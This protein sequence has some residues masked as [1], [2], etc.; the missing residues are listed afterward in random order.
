[1][2]EAVGSV[3]SPFPGH[4]IRLYSITGAIEKKTWLFDVAGVTYFIK[5]KKGGRQNNK[6]AHEQHITG[7]IGEAVI[8]ARF[9]ITRR[10][11][12]SNPSLVEVISRK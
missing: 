1:M 12:Q 5:P 4:E 7:Q 2:A 6:S 3:S 10:N 9:G 11:G 8:R